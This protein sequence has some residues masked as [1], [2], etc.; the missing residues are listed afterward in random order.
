MEK[1]DFI[2]VV[3]IVV[4]AG[5]GGNGAVTFRREKYIPYGGPDGGDGG[6]G[7]FVFLIADPT[8]STLYH[9]TEKKRY[10]AQNGENGRK[11]KQSGKNGNDVILRVPVGTIVKDFET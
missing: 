5:D 6:D 10:I 7:G 1:I 11:K 4:K 2:D 8:L 9:L 3:D